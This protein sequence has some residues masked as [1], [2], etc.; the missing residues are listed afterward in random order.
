MSGLND[1]SRTHATL[2]TVLVV[3]DIEDRGDRPI[4]Q[5]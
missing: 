3:V 2:A 5:I 4:R 1:D